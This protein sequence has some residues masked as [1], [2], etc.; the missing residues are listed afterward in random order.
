M[1][2]FVCLS[3]FDLFFLFVC[4]F[5]FHLCLICVSLSQSSL[6]FILFLSFS[7]FFPFPSLLFNVKFVCLFL[8]A[9]MNCF[10]IRT[11]R[12]HFISRIISSLNFYIFSSLVPVISIS[13]NYSINFYSSHSSAFH[14]LSSP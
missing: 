10:S 7:L 1:C 3:C 2:V 6:F 8:L 5:L 14:L 9:F 13:I 11:T 4:L 12:L